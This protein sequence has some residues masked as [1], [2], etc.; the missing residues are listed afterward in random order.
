M[1][2]LTR[3]LCW[4]FVRLIGCVVREAPPEACDV[5][6]CAHTLRASSASWV[7]LKP[8]GACCITRLECVEAPP[9][10]PLDTCARWHVVLHVRIARWC[11]SD[12]MPDGVVC[13]F[14]R[15]STISSRLPG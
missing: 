15:I 11:S 7:N 10:S 13:V 1:L 14:V 2:V 8:L 4:S 6:V 9:A 12:L 5:C 3:A